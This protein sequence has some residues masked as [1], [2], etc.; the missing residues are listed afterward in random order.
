MTAKDPC[1]C[2]LAP[3][4]VLDLLDA[5]QRLWVEEQ[6]AA[7]PDLA[8]ELTELQGTTATVAYS[9]PDK[10]PSAGLKSRLFNTLGCPLPPQQSLN[11]R[12]TAEP[13]LTSA[14]DDDFRT[15]LETL[16]VRSQERVWQPQ[17]TPGVMVSILHTDPIKREIIGLLKA[18]PGVQ[19]PNHRHAGIEDIFMLEGDLVVAGA[20]YRQGDYIR[21]APG[22]G[23]GPHTTG[24]CMFFFRTSMDDEYPDPG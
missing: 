23:H 10:V 21:S 8:L 6:A 16:F 7:D 19:Y 22:S 20:V 4:Y 11:Q 2:D 9:A 14:S 18:E 17:G 5:E 15:V 1:F 3:L 13:S 12:S 24:G